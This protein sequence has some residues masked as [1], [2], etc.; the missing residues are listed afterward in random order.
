MREKIVDDISIYL[1]N[2][3]Q[4]PCYVSSMAECT[5]APNAGTVA[6]GMTFN[7]SYTYDVVCPMLYTTDYSA[8]ATWVKEN[9]DY[10]KNLGYSKILPSLQ[11]YKNGTTAT[12]NDDIKATLEDGCMGYLLFRTNTYDMAR[13]T[14]TQDG[15]VEIT[16]IR[17]TQYSSGDITITFKGAT[18]QTVT[19]GCNLAT[20]Q[21]SIDGPTITFN[22]DALNSLGDYGTITIRFLNGKQPTSIN[23]ESDKRIVYNAPFE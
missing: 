5:Y 9:I 11:A 3:T 1:K 2:Q 22:A 4:R 19:M 17:G 20:T 21:Y 7:Q 14:K 23:V 13:A 15:A 12:L 8:D 16:Y 18:P 10:L 6:Y